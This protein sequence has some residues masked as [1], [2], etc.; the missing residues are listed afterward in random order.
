[1]TDSAGQSLQP[2]SNGTAYS[3]LNSLIEWVEGK[4]STGPHTMVGTKYV[5]DV[6][7]AG[8][9]FTRPYCRWPTIPVFNGKGDVNLA[10]NW[11]CPS[12]GVY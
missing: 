4:N 1:M 3:L 5:G 7:S 10:E 11:S 9:K 12:E 2:A 6:A 8:V